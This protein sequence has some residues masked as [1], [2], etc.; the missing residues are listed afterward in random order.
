MTPEIIGGIIQGGALVLLALVLFSISKKIDA[1][2]LMTERILY[3]LIDRIPLPQLPNP[4]DAR[5]LKLWDDEE[6]DSSVS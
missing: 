3:K 5:K 2:I 6:G 1:V 4:Q